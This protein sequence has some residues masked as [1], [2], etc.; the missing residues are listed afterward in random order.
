[1]NARVY[2]CVC[3]SVRVCRSV[4]DCVCMCLCEE[5]ERRWQGSGEGAEKLGRMKER[6]KGWGDVEKMVMPFEVKHRNLLS[7]TYM[8]ARAHASMYIHTYKHARK[9]TIHTHMH[10][11]KHT[12][13]RA[14]TRIHARTHKHT[15]TGSAGTCS[16]TNSCSASVI[17][18]TTV[19]G[20][21]AV[22]FA[23]APSDPRT[24][25]GRSLPEGMTVGMRVGMSVNMR[26]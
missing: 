7:D 5:G 26:I 3:V 2:M 21:V 9:H 18:S 24:C 17:R 14:H 12:C 6:S 10:T 15:R 23:V 19:V 25:R 16:N 1:M 8:Q 22:P 13:T 11:R 20:G 4:C